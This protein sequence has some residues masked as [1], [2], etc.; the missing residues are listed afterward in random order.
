ML[1]ASLLIPQGAAVFAAD[2]ATSVLT[3]VK[4][5]VEIPAELTEFQT[6]V[7][8]NG[9]K[10]IYE[11]SW[12]DKEHNSSISVS[13]DSAGRIS[14]YNRYCA[15]WYK[16]N[17]KLK[18]FEET[19]LSDLEWFADEKLKELAPQN[20]S[21]DYD[22]FVRLPY[23]DKLSLDT[24][25]TYI[26]NYVR[27]HDG[28]E[29]KDDYANVVLT[30]FGDTPQ[31]VVSNININWDYNTEFIEGKE[32]ISEADAQK[33]LA[34]KFPLKLV[35]RKNY[36][37]KYFLEYVQN[38][39]D[40]ISATDGEKITEDLPDHD[41][42][43]Y[44]EKNAA[45]EDLADGGAGSKASLTPE[46]I[47][48]LEKVNGLKTKDELMSVLKSM[49]ELKVSPN[50]GA[51]INSYLYKQDDAYYAD[52]NFTE[53]Q[54]VDSSYVY[55]RFNAKTGELLSFN[56]SGRVYYITKD[57]ETEK[58]YSP[59]AADAFLKKYYAARVSDS[60]KAD[61]E[62]NV[63]YT[64]L[65]NGIEYPD[66]YIGAAADKDGRINSFSVS[67]DE[68]TSKLPNPDKIITLAEATSAMFAKYPISLRYIKVDKMFTPAYTFSSYGCRINAFTGKSVDYD[69]EEITDKKIGGYTDIEGHWS[70]QIAEKLA[71]YG[72]GFEESTLNPDS[73]ITQADF[74]KL[75]YTGILGYSNNASYED[76]YKRLIDRSVLPKEEMN[77]TA[78]ITREKAIRY[79]LRAMGI[80]EVAEIPGIYVCDFADSGDIS[81][82]LLGYCAI[83]KGFKIVKGSD[84]CLYPQQNITRAEA[85]AMIYNYLTR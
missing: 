82:E 65:V 1:A 6:S 40:Y 76:L 70:A 57:G 24:Q 30:S 11:F 37:N 13:A 12:N 18:L 10:T 68:D 69:G 56:R 41:I 60:T 73:K 75:I 80:T 3:A 44:L 17:N 15:D 50:A 19:K 35:Y 51:D 59:E 74:L 14:E 71:V 22:T 4:E 23:N 5:R 16:D 39:S 77:S 29:V 46:E 32:L 63:Y 33:S 64:R 25:S 54:G 49:P 21:G 72:I 81:P 38:S 79:L 20:F 7:S 84:G 27:K 9:G 61:S 31:V 48:E 36:D 42:R 34:E 47:S 58:D 85:L 53:T 26:F 52:I 67:W 83:A 55:S 45:A 28:I 2:E 8:S 66:N 78:P 43:P 62:T